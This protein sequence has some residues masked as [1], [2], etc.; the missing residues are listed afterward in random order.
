MMFR[1]LRLLLAYFALFAIASGVH[2]DESEGVVEQS[3]EDYSDEW[4]QN[5]EF[6]DDYDEEEE[7]EPFFREYPHI[8]EDERLAE[9]HA[10]NYN[11][12]LESMVPNTEGWRRLMERRI[13]QLEQMEG[14]DEYRYKG[15]IPTMASALTVPNFTEHGWGLTRAPADLVKKLRDSLYNGFANAYEEYHTNIIEADGLPLFIDQPEL[16]VEV[17]R[18]L[19]PMHEEWS[20]VPLNALTAYGMWQDRQMDIFYCSSSAASSLTS[21]FLPF[22]GLRVYR[23]NSNLLMHV[24]R[25]KRKSH[26]EV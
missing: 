2:G 16:N 7:E 1:S 18:R 23:N 15:W 24:D 9:Y 13:Q 21:L 11:W 22:I 14:D 20:G 5:E 6:E 25:G 8:E 26:W 3:E 19:K 10:R 12:P 17:L 4:D